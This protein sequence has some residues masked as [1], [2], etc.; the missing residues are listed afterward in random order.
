[1]KGEEN[2]LSSQPRALEPKVETRTCTPAFVTD[3]KNRRAPHIRGILFFTSKSTCTYLYEDP[4]LW[5]WSVQI[6]LKVLASFY[7]YGS[8]QLEFTDTF[9]L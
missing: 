4:R 1:M 9:W 6:L 2:E 5:K 7:D 8:W 3:L